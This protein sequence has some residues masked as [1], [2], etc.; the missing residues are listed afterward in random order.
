M[1]ASWHGAYTAAATSERVRV[2]G[3]ITLELDDEGLIDRLR[4]WAIPR[5]VGVDGR[6]EPASRPGPGTEVVDG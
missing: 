1:L 5:A 3:F 4:L 2:R 6:H